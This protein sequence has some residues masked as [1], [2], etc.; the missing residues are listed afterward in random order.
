M[1]ETECQHLLGQNLCLLV[2]CLYITQ[3]FLNRKRKSMSI[4]QAF[5]QIEVYFF[6]H[7]WLME[8]LLEES[9]TFGGFAD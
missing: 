3:C 6:A 9:P 2:Q 5:I 7:L 1:V 4:S 8:D